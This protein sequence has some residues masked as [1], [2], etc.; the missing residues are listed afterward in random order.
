MPSELLVPA[1]GVL[2]AI[3]ALSVGYPAHGFP[4]LSEAQG[5]VGSKIPR[6]S[7]RPASF[8][9]VLGGGGPALDLAADEFTIILEGW[10]TSEGLAE[11]ITAFGV[12]ILQAAAR[13]G[14]VGGIPSRRVRVGSLPAPLPD[15]TV[16][17]HFRFTSTLA[18]VL[19]RSAA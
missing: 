9:R 1:D 3:A 2:A 16:T 18:V 13:D 6:V 8:V 7:P 19:R 15:P 5:T 12:A 10:A 4:A 11:R 17:S 14:F